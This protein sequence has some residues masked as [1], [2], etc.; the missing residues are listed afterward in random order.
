MWSPLAS[1]Q[2]VNSAVNMETAVS[3]VQS[4]PLESAPPVAIF[5]GFL[6]GGFEQTACW[7]RLVPIGSDWFWS[8]WTSQC[9]FSPSQFNFRPWCGW[10]CCSARHSPQWTNRSIW[11]TPLSLLSGLLTS[12]HR[13]FR[14]PWTR[15]MAIWLAD[16]FFPPISLSFSHWLHRRLFL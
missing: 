5:L 12:A 10:T 11:S 6:I 9:R 16:Y 1:C 4:Q 7:F 15:I 3:A 2:N 8:R 13:D 14:S